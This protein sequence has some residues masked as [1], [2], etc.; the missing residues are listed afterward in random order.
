MND[1]AGWTK[2]GRCVWC[3]SKDPST[4]CLDV[5]DDLRKGLE[6]LELCE[7]FVDDNEVSC[8]EAIYQRDIIIEKSY[9]LVESMCDIVGYSSLGESQDD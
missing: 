2:R 1:H 3:G 7:T 6:L 8:A 4:E 9:E 5:G